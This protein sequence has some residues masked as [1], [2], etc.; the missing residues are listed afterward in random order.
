MKD[1]IYDVLSQG[2]ISVILMR[3]F[4]SLAHSSFNCNLVEESKQMGVLLGDILIRLSRQHHTA[5]SISIPDLVD[6]VICRYTSSSPTT[7]S[8]SSPNTKMNNSP[9]SIIWKG[10]AVEIMESG[11][12]EYIS[13]K[14]I[15]VIEQKKMMKHLTELMAECAD[16]HDA[17][18]GIVFMKTCALL[19]KATTER[20]VFTLFDI[21]A[22]QKGYECILSLLGCCIDENSVS[23]V[24]PN[25][26][27]RRGVRINHQP[28]PHF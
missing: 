17:A 12:L 24:C 23:Y 14:D 21:F 7:T 22:S 10:K 8:F 5:T 28:T 16:R 25:F 27:S 4:S 1:A 18:A 9:T 26:L 19:L 3:V 6:V 2:N 13:E 15:T 20:S 11:L